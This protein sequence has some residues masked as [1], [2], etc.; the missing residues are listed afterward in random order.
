MKVAASKLDVLIGCLEGINKPPLIIHNDGPDL[1]GHL[2]LVHLQL[3]GSCQ[4]CI[5][6]FL[7]AGE[8]S[9][10]SRHSFAHG[11]QPKDKHDRGE[12]GTGS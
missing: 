11:S 4:P 9:I 12:E 2:Q 3:D 10:S 6:N 7:L 1:V 5:A 8:E